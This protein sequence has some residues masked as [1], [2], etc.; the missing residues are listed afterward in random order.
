M[1]QDLNK[2]LHANMCMTRPH[3]GQKAHLFLL[4]RLGH[5]ESKV[6]SQTNV[7]GLVLP[8]DPGYFNDGDVVRGFGGFIAVSELLCEFETR[9]SKL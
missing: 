2:Q 6:C 4:L 1:F 7:V 3:N 8:L 9:Q 5:Y